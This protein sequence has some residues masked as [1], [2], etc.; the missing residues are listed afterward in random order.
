MT[1][2]ILKNNPTI[3]ERTDFSVT[4]VVNT[5]GIIYKTNKTEDSSD[6]YYYSGNTTNNWVKFGKYSSISSISGRY[7]ADGSEFYDEFNTME[8]C[9]SHWLYS[10]HGK[11]GYLWKK[12]DD[13]Y[14]RIIR[15]NEDGSIRL[16]YAGIS[17]NTTEGN[18][19]ASDYNSSYDD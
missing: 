8:E 12:D 13:M 19:G 17:P 9:T 4:N 6:V 2:A 16:L 18:I 5:T 3:E 7:Y 1:D 10:E 15:T 14:W 11:C